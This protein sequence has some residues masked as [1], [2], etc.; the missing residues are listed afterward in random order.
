MGPATSLAFDVDSDYSSARLK[1][2]HLCL[3]Y[4]EEYDRIGADPRQCQGVRA[5][6]ALLPVL[7]NDS[8]DP[9][10]FETA[11][12]EARIYG[13]P[14]PKTSTETAPNPKHASF[15]MLYERIT[16]AERRQFMGQEAA[17]FLKSLTWPKREPVVKS[18]AALAD[19]SATIT[20]TAPS[21]LVC[22]VFQDI[23][24]ATYPTVEATLKSKEEISHMVTSEYANMVAMF[25]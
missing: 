3:V 13:S 14:P 16:T 6:H 25:L 21:P 9:N 11:M 15:I 23:R 8:T 5:I 7:R 2:I 10:E 20:D 22:C 24:M 18:L 17:I 1:L 12:R 19:G 4:L